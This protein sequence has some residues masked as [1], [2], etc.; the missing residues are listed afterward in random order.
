MELIFAGANP[1]IIVFLF[2]SLFAFLSW[3]VK[4]LIEKPISESKNTFNRFV[5]KRIEILTQ[6]NSHLKFILYFIGDVDECKSHKEKL[7]DI[8][9]R[10][11]KV[12]YI[13]KEDFESVLKLS[14][15]E[16]TDEAEL[17]RIIASLDTDLYL[18]ISKIE[19]EIKFYKRFSNYNL[20]KRFVGLLILSLQYILILTLL[21]FVL[22]SFVY[23]V[24]NNGWL[25]R[26]IIILII[27]VVIY[28]LSCWIDK[29]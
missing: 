1:T 25:I 28:G 23:F 20:L 12:A 11:G 27:I 19:D 29:Q 16:E 22:F 8:L 7:Q 5:E 15:D 4:G 21:L 24:I 9:L 26:S 2:T 3:I 17:I 10:D 6:V 18:Q 13:N 14:I